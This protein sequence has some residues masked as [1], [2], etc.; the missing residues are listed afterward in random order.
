MQQVGVVGYGYVGQ[1]I[2]KLFQ[3]RFEL[4]VH[5]PAKGHHSSYARLKACGLVL[6]CVPTPSR[7]DGAAD[8]SMVE[9]VM[10]ELAG[11]RGLICIKSTVP[12]GT[13]DRLAAQH[14]VDVHFSP[15][16]I[17][18]GLR[19]STRYMH[20]TDPAQHPFVMV[21]GPRAQAVLDFFRQAMVVDARFIACR[22]VEAEL[23]K[24]ME[25]SY[26][27]VKVAFCHEWSRIAGA[28]GVEY[29]ALR[30]LWLSDNRIEAD[31]TAVLP[32]STGYGGRCLP[33]DMAAIIHAAEVGGVQP[34]V[35]HAVHAANKESAL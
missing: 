30:E 6:I 19:T 34:R 13:S 10:R 26:F 31:H 5:D 7:D 2:A 23:C 21:G 17:G 16:Y 8:V 25:N 24:Y 4:V 1:A 12:P 11:T 9:E 27:A 18:E 3:G 20:Q 14:G 15:E 32:G 29:G 33:K 22:A 28:F 35:L